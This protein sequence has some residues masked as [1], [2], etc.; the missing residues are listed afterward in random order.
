MPESSWDELE[1][2]GRATQSAAGGSQQAEVMRLDYM[3]ILWPSHEFIARCHAHRL[4]SLTPG[5]DPGRGGRGDGGAVDSP[6]GDNEQV[7][8]LPVTL[9]QMGA[10]VQS[11][12][13]R[14][15]VAPSLLRPAGQSSGV[16]DRA[17]VKVPHNKSYLRM[18]GTHASSSASGSGGCL[19]REIAW[20]L[21]TSACLSLGA[22]GDL[23]PPSFCKECGH[24]REVNAAYTHTSVS[25]SV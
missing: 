23:V 2:A 24:V 19:C 17:T 16:D 10:D 21:L 12:L 22:Q 20:L 6:L 18:M 13:H 5:A 9:V 14:Y 3:K 1:E 25:G 7:F 4:P 8:F 15:S 11:Q